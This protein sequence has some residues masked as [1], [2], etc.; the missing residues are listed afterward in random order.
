M[1]LIQNRDNKKLMGCHP[2]VKFDED[3][4]NPGTLLENLHVVK[5][6]IT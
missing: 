4:G 6:A 1:W 3:I 2:S 5:I